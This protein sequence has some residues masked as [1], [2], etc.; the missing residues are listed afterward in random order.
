[1]QRREKRVGE[2]LLKGTPNCPRQARRQGSRTQH[3]SLTGFCQCREAS[4]QGGG[5][6]AHGHKLENPERHTAWEPGS[7]NGP[8]WTLICATWKAGAIIPISWMNKAKLRE[9]ALYPQ[10]GCDPQWLRV[11]I[12]ESL[13]LL[14]FEFLP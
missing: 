9:K 14:S 2:A 5:E 6:V 7:H 12:L 8:S 4:F 13:T 10:G 1:M 3:C 11:G